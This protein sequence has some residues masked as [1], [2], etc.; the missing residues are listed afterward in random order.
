MRHRRF[1]L[2][3]DH[4]VSGVSGRGRVAEGVEF[5][6]GMCAMTFISQFHCVNVYAN[7]KAVLQVHGHGGATRLV[8]DDPEDS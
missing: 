5:S 2:E 4:D 7:V 3:R 1:H 6:N 8:W